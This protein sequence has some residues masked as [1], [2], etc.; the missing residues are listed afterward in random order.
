M[1][2]SISMSKSMSISTYAYIYQCLYQYRSAVISSETVKDKDNK[3]TYLKE[4]I[5]LKKI[6]ILKFYKQ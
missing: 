5:M 6:V 2:I 3:T 4:N 1:S